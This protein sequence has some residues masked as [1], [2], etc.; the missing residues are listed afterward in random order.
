MKKKTH[1]T[2][3][4]ASRLLSSV[5]PS[6]VECKHKRRSSSSSLVAKLVPTSLGN[7]VVERRRNKSRNAPLP[8]SAPAK[9]AVMVRGLQTVS[10][11]QIPVGKRAMADMDGKWG[12]LYRI[13]A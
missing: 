1:S 9:F 13:G 7:R 11:P 12:C 2:N 4:K 8:T 10:E 5:A 3:S 6:F